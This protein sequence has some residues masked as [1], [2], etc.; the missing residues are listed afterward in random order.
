MLVLPE[1][2]FVAV[3]MSIG[4][5]PMSFSRAWREL[6]G[7]ALGG[8]RHL[9]WFDV[10]AASAV[11]SLD[12]S[13]FQARLRCTSPAPCGR[14]MVAKRCAGLRHG[15][16]PPHPYATPGQPGS[17]DRMIRQPRR[18]RFPGEGPLPPIPLGLPPR[19]RLTPGVFL[20]VVTPKNCSRL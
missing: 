16:L 2:R 14:D 17:S 8:I 5:C 20:R 18:P 11:H 1:D 7:G 9:S 19:A 10:R 12:S 3:Q 15:A 6:H 4:A 13:C